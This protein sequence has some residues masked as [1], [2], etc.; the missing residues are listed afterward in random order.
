MAKNEQTTVEEQDINLDEL[1]GVTETSVMTP[2]E[3][4]VKNIFTDLTP[5]TSFLDKKPVN[6]NTDSDSDPE[7][8][9]L[10]QNAD[11][12]D[13]LKPPTSQVT[14]SKNNVGR[15]GSLVSVTKKLVEKGI[16][17]PFED[18]K[19]I[20]DYTQE[21]IEEL[22]EANFSHLKEEYTSELPEH[23][24][25]IFATLP[26]ELQD[27]YAYVKSGGTDMKGLFRA[28]AS[29]VE[30]NSL[31]VTNEHHQKDIIRTY[32][33]ATRWGD[34]AEIEDEI[35]SLEDKGEL[36]KKARQFKPK[37]DNMQQEV[38]NQKILA[39]Q[40]ATRQRAE[41]SQLYMDSVYETIKPGVLNGLKM[42]VK[43]QKLLYEGLTRPAY[44]S[45]SGR[46]TNLLGHLLEK[47]QWV[48][49]RHDLI[50]EALWLLADPDGYRNNVRKNVETDVNAKTLR[51]LK[52]EQNNNK[53]LGTGTE[54]ADD[55]T[56]QTP[57]RQGLP[58]KNENFFRR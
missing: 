41:Q 17:V 58:R 4:P 14:Q 46:P 24:D 10:D 3:E 1:L 40:E 13:P 37:L 6:S 43:T 49:P 38:V 23:I 5:D 18:E 27:A 56:R 42:D 34:A 55:D 25:Q 9:S 20:E 52:T 50:A 31:D 48:E 22:I 51:T 32:L 7:D 19:S 35:N 15:P 8:E 44:P 54:D 53:G 16:L 45:G 28:L 26:Q 30:I 2:G 57:K 11:S 21:D 47:Y 36:E 12:N 33:Q 29:T 39:Q